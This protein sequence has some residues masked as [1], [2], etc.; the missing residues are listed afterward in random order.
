MSAVFHED[1][2]T[3]NP[4]DKFMAP[5]APPPRPSL[6]LITS[7]PSLGRSHSVRSLSPKAEKSIWSPR[8]FFGRWSEKAPSSTAVRRRSA[9]ERSGRGKCDV[10]TPISIKH[11]QEE[12][13]EEKP[14]LPSLDT[15]PHSSMDLRPQN[16]L[17][18]W[19]FVRDSVYSATS[20]EIPDEIA[21][22]DED[23][24]NFA[25]QP[26]RLSFAEQQQLTP[27]TP[28][29]AARSSIARLPSVRSV[30]TRALRDTSKP[31]PQLPRDDNLLPPPLRLRPA[32]Y[33][34][35]VQGSHFSISTAASE[36][37]SPVQSD[38]NTSPRHS[39]I[40]DI[41]AD[42]DNGA[43]EDDDADKDGDADEEDVGSDD[44]SSYCPI[45]E[46]PRVDFDFDGYGS[47]DTHYSSEETSRKASPLSPKHS[48]ATFGADMTI[49]ASGSLSKDAEEDKVSSLE[50]IL[51]ELGYLGDA[52]EGC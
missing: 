24:D 47:P 30:A 4:H 18:P 38:F 23:D 27:L 1:I 31:L 16:P 43:G 41:D 50:L 6:R 34:L 32:F 39:V 11:W 52:I 28:F 19:P 21:E 20:L 51:S 42:E 10:G 36:A 40:S 2:K 7:S 29:P 3:M 5:R 26:H 37:T 9:S 46:I 12:T 33:S 15:S 44:E 25:S 45:G 48:R 8:T 22:G 14:V 49:K 35:G 13:P 17:S